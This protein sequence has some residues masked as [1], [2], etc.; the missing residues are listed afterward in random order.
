MHLK[1]KNA[2]ASRYSTISKVNKPMGMISPMTEVTLKLLL[3]RL[4][5]TIQ[6]EAFSH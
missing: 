2:T 6:Q 4:H 3:E 1:P 5:L